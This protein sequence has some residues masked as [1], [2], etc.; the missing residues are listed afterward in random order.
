MRIFLAVFFGLFFH[1]LS[2][3]HASDIQLIF[4]K[5]NSQ[6]VVNPSKA[7]DLIVFIKKNYQN[8]YS[9]FYCNDTIMKNALQLIIQTAFLSLNLSLTK[10]F[11]D[12]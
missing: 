4:N 5:I 7:R 11:K 2:A 3:Q 8:N 1:Q 6:I 10:N 9:C 12:L